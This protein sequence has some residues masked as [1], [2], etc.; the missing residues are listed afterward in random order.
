MLLDFPSDYPHLDIVLESI[1]ELP[2][3]DLLRLLDEL[4]LGPATRLLRFRFLS[5]LLDESSEFAIGDRYRHLRE[6]AASLSRGGF[7]GGRRFGSWRFGGTGRIA[8]FEFERCA[9][10]LL[11]VELVRCPLRSARRGE[12]YVPSF[13][14]GKGL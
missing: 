5:E 1:D 2:N 10:E 3:N 7:G 9:R 13:P 11:V 4:F 6:L 12:R 8:D 14:V